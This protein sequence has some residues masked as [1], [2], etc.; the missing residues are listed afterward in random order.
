M[1]DSEHRE[2]VAAAEPRLRAWGWVFGA[3]E[4]DDTDT[5]PPVYT[6][7]EKDWDGQLDLIQAWVTKRGYQLSGHEIWSIRQPANA[8][9]AFLSQ[10]RIPVLVIPGRAIRDRMRATWE[11]WPQV[12]TDVTAA[13][14]RIEIAE[15]DG[16]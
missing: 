3:R 10:Q 14:V 8:L 15:H 13:G 6:D 2:A 1:A 7:F 5:G 12:V 11:C 4:I 9:A 16:S